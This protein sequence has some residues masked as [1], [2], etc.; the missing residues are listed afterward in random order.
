MTLSILSRLSDMMKVA[1]RSRPTSTS[2]AL[3]EGP[4][5]TLSS[6]ACLSSQG[7]HMIT[8]TNRQR[9]NASDRTQHDERQGQRP[10]R[11]RDSEGN[12]ATNRGRARRDERTKQETARAGCRPPRPPRTEGTTR[13]PAPDE[14]RTGEEGKQ[15]SK[16][17]KPASA[18]P[19]ARPERTGAS[20][21]KT[22]DEPSLSTTGCTSA[23]RDSRC[24]NLIL[25]EDGS[26]SRIKTLPDDSL[27]PLRGFPEKQ[28][29]HE[30]APPLTSVRIQVAQ[31]HGH[32]VTYGPSELSFVHA[33][34]SIRRDD[35][36]EVPQTDLVGGEPGA[37]GG[38]PCV[39]IMFHLYL[40]QVVVRRGSRKRCKLDKIRASQSS[41]VVGVE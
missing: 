15:E 11:G 26:P 5:G 37:Q 41:D 1:R 30:A 10:G 17:C 35:L 2:R 29:A 32:C 23:C 19:T 38:P 27:L 28:F 12:R 16:Q 13:T 4:W 24:H 25:G 33:G 14:G 40:E 18:S 22:V 36:S 39:E 20:Q 8:V 21:S 34:W 3:L 6:R 9:G 31:V 7:L